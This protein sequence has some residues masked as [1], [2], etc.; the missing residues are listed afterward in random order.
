MSNT[1]QS[2]AKPVVQVISP[3]KP[4]PLKY[5]SV[6]F[7]SSIDIAGND[8]GL[9]NEDMY[10]VKYSGEDEAVDGGQKLTQYSGKS[11]IAVNLLSLI[12]KLPKKILTTITHPSVMVLI[13]LAVLGVTGSVISFVSGMPEPAANGLM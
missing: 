1:P 11:A 8:P 12:K 6:D 7:Y 4:A 2:A 10:A 3:P 9:L 5:K 13:F